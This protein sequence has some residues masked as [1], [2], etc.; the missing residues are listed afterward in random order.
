[1]KL[2][3]TTMT[4]CLIFALG[5]FVFGQETVKP[6]DNT[7][8]PT[9]KK[10]D[11][12][13]KQ[14]NKNDDPDTP[15]I[16]ELNDKK[17]GVA[18]VSKNTVERY[19][20]GYQDTLEVRVIRHD[21]LS[22]QYNVNPDGTINL[23]R[24][25]KPIIA[26]CKTESE[27]A[28]DIVD[29]YKENYLRNPYVNVRAVD[30]K[31]QSFSVIGAVEKPGTFYVNRR[32]SLLELLAYAGGPNDDAGQ[33]LIV[34]RPGSLTACRD[35]SA[36]ATFDENSQMTL[37]DFKIKEVKEGKQSLWMEPGD[38]V[39]VLDVDVVYVVGNVNKA[40]EIKLKEP[41]TLSQ[42]IAKAEGVKDTTNKENVVILRRKE[43]S[44]DREELV[45][46]LK[47]I[48]QQ[49]ISDPVLQPNDIVAVSKDKTKVAVRGIMDV[50]K[51]G[52]P[53]IFY[54]IF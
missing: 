22:G 39:S 23:P 3:G 18:E 25:D 47:D 33:K 37:L 21:D 41:I 43:D 34:A 31:S 1:M 51:S 24:I 48:E 20:I 14:I 53:S 10:I 46:N 8:K 19:R 9:A 36:V 11:N 30:Q 40:Q 7:V 42:A 54:R 17:P 29:A 32:I 35:E 4:F 45:Y 5:T 26:V 50:L 2:F 49:K 13:K 44:F 6:A 27:L 15:E 28:K 52:L 16:I 12:G 38:I